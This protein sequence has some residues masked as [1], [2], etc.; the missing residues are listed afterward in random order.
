LDVSVVDCKN[1]LEI[2]RL[3]TE[4]LEFSTEKNKIYFIRPTCSNCDYRE[5]D[6]LI[7]NPNMSAKTFRYNEFTVHLGN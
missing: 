4:I 2:Y 5:T 6:Q 7:S 3:N 1:N